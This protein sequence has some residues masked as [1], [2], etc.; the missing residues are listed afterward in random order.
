VT[1]RDI[2]LPFECV[3]HVGTFVYC[4]RWVSSCNYCCLL[5]WF[6]GKEWDFVLDV[7]IADDAPP[8]K[9]AFQ[10]DE[11]PYTVAARFLGEHQL[12]MGYKEQIVKFI[13]QNGASR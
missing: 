11:N 2:Q 3:L 8:L 1:C 5:Q 6:N 13:L 10:Q 7:N 12:P 4:K 9:L